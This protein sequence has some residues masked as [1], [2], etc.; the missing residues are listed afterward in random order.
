MYIT[1]IT[2]EKMNKSRPVNDIFQMLFSYFLTQPVKLLL[3]EK[4]LEHTIVRL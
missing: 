4:S 2:S 1:K 3:K